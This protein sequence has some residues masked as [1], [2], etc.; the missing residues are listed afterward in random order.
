MKR[1]SNC[2]SVLTFINVKF[3]KVY[4][5]YFKK[6]IIYGFKLYDIFF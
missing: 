3:S 4:V 6:N 1:N 2:D 5:L